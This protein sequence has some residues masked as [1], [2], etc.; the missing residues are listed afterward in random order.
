MLLPYSTPHATWTRSRSRELSRP[1]V[2]VSRGTFC[3]L[4]G[5][6]GHRAVVPEWACDMLYSSHRSKK[7]LKHVRSDFT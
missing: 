7:P 6:V 1:S 4:Q 3:T 5:D 2:S